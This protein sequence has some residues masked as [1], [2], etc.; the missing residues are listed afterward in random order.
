MVSTR[1]F[2]VRRLAPAILGA[3]VLTSLVAMPASAARGLHLEFGVQPADIVAGQAIAPAVT[4]RVLDRSDSLVTNKAYPVTLAIASNPGGATLFG[5]KTVNSV[6][7]VATFGQLTVDKSGSGYTLLATSPDIASR[8]SAP[9]DVSGFAQQCLGNQCSLRTGS[10]TAGNPTNG[11]ASVPVDGCNAA[12]CFL[13]QE[14]ITGLTCGDE[15]CLNG[16]GVAVYPPPNSSAAV[17]FILENYYTPDSGGIGNREV[18][19]VKFSGEEI[20]LDRC[21][22]RPGNR[23]CILK[24]SATQGS[25]VSVTVQFPPNDPLVKH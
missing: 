6:A 21:P 11:A 7:G 17:K 20:V 15:P 12:F 22:R 9:F 2:A 14:V 19:L 24:A 4:V 13:S 16:G 5:V 3:F 18:Y 10:T 25:I 1:S 8:V 23:A